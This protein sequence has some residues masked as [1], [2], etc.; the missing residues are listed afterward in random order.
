MQLHTQAIDSE[1]VRREQRD[2]QT[3]LVAPVVLVQ[4]MELNG[5]Y[6]PQREIERSADEWDGVPVTI[7][8]PEHQ[9]DPVSVDDERADVPVIGEVRNPEAKAGGERLVGELWVNVVE[10]KSASRAGERVVRRLENGDAVEVSTGYIPG[11]VVAGQF[12]GEHRERAVLDIQPDHLATLPNDQGK[13]SLADGCGA[14]APR[15][16]AVNQLFIAAAAADDPEQG[17][18]CG[19]DEA[20]PDDPGSFPPNSDAVDDEV[21]RSLGERVLNALGW[22]PDDDP[23]DPDGPDGDVDGTTE[24]QT[25]DEPAESGADSTPSEPE[26]P[27][28]PKMGDK[29]EELVENHDF[30]AENLPAEDTECFNRIYEAVTS[31][32]EDPD[33]SDTTDEPTTTNDDTDGDEEYVT[34]DELSD[35]VSDAV[36]DALEANRD[37]QRRSELVDEITANTERDRE[38]LEDLDVQALEVLAEELPAGGAANFAAQT[39]ARASPSTNDADSFPALTAAERAAE[40]DE[41]AD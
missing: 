21:K 15:A 33:G 23:D 13:C 41:E 20:M 9:G 6:L 28:D 1:S 14:G 40:L 7:D 18:D 8:H 30:D 39:G 22:S 5:G 36:S 34:K 37:E 31:N 38:D 2:G 17:E 29:T 19:E 35:V 24:A 25:R 3:F 32:D 4:A 12:D 27:E 16:P 11:R 10:A 26:A